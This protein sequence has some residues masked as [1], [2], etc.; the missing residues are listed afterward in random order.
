MGHLIAISNDIV[1]AANFDP[2]IAELVNSNHDWHQFVNKTLAERNILES[3]IMGQSPMD[4]DYDSRME[5]EHQFQQ[6][7]MHETQDEND[8]VHGDVDMLEDSDSDSDSDNGNEDIQQSSSQEIDQDT[9]EATTGETP[10]E[11]HND[12]D[13]TGVEQD[14]HTGDEENINPHVHSLMEAGDEHHLHQKSEEHTQNS[15]LSSDLKE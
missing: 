15:E 3:T 6:I 4:Y 11:K 5:F 13:A 12:S 7:A 14:E 2:L 10:G 9:Q 8:D 1:S